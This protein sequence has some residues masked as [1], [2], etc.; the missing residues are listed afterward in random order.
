MPAQ[1]VDFLESG[2]LYL[3]NSEI[4]M[5]KKSNIA[6]EDFL[7]LNENDLYRIGLS[8]GSVKRITLL[9]K[10]ISR[11]SRIEVPSTNCVHVYI[12]NS[13][14]WIEGK[15]TVENL[16]RLVPSTLTGVPIILNS[17]RS[18]MAN[19]SPQFKTDVN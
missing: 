13:N 3:T 12:D 15:Y 11:T 4:E 6:G 18:I 9:M 7:L 16:E 19:F 8:I 2:D 10:K 5:I 14:I 17:S 1:F